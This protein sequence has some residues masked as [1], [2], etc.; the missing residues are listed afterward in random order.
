VTRALLAIGTMYA[1][2]LLCLV[3]SHWLTRWPRVALLNR[4]LGTS[5]GVFATGL[6]FLLVYAVLFPQETAAA[7][8]QRALDSLRARVEALEQRRP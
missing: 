8:Q 7:R 5:V 6:T 3:L 4:Y 2:A 1:F